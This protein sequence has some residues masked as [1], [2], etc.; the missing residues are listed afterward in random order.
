MGSTTTIYVGNYLE[1]TGSTTSMKKYY[2]ANGQ[3]V[4][5]R[6]GSSTLYY[7]LTDHLGSTAITATSG[8]G[9]S[10]EMRYFPW[11][12]TRYTYG[13]TPTSFRYTGQR[14][15]GYINLYWY[16]SRWYD[17]ALGRFIQPDTIVPESVQGVQAW[18][19]YAYVSNSPIGII[20]PTGHWGLSFNLSN[21]VNSVL[22]SVGVNSTNVVN[23]LNTAS[24]ILDVVGL[25]ID[26]AIAT[27]D[28]VS[29]VNGAFTGG[30]A[31]IPEAGAP[32][33]VTVPA[34]AAVAMGA[35]ELNPVT[36]GAM[37]AGNILAS[38]STLL[39]AASD[40]IAGETNVALSLGDNGFS[41]AS[42]IGRDTFTSGVSCL[43]GWF[44]PIGLIS[45][46]LAAI[47]VANDFGL[48]YTGPLSIV[49]QSIPIISI[50][51]GME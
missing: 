42:S 10:A 26:T 41:Y 13:T 15:D 33:V 19:R 5:M 4:A 48:L 38:A 27:G 6:Q 24:T 21:F 30:F 22:N 40:V 14:E 35:F 20:D 39:T 3:R 51:I 7:L 36:R 18:D 44:S 43:A 32:S 50:D 2:Y 47:P 16:G 37:N 11:G 28:V 12:G 46:P 1:W 9:I 49:P 23:G 8:G 17:Q 34:G 45:A 25:V 31:S 29:A